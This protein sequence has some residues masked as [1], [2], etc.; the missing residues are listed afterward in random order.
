MLNLGTHNFCVSNYISVNYVC[1]RSTG[2]KSENTFAFLSEIRV[3]IL[4]LQHCNTLINPII[5]NGR[6]RLRILAK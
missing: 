5:E 4:L 6:V 3:K 2:K 1:L